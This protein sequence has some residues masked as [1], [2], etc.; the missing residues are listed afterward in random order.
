MGVQP[1]S[2]VQVSLGFSVM[3]VMCDALT[4]EAFD[5]YGHL[6]SNP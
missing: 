6:S 5:H 3:H 1:G 4:L 2:G